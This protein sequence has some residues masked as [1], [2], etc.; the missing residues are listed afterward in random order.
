MTVQETVWLQQLHDKLAKDADVFSDPRYNGIWESIIDKYSDQAHFV[1]ELLQ[2]A[3]DA[4]ATWVRF[5]LHSQELVFRHNGKKLFTVSNPETEAE[6]QQNGKLGHVNAIAAI[7]MSQKLIENKEGNQIGKFG[8]GFKSVFRYTNTPRIYDD[9]IGFRIERRIVP[10]IIDHDYNGRLSGETVFVFPFDYGDVTKSYSEVANKLRTLQ[11]P[12][13]FLKNLKEIRYKTE[14]DDGTYSKECGE[15]QSFEYKTDGVE[16]RKLCT[17]SISIMHRDEKLNMQ[18]FTRDLEKGQAVSVAFVLNDAGQPCPSP[19][20]GAF[21]FFQT[22]VPTGLNFIVHAPFLL[23]DNRQG[24]KDDSLL[25]SSG[26]RQAGHNEQMIWECVSLAADAVWAFTQLEGERIT[27]QILEVIPTQQGSFNGLPFD[28]LFRRNVEIIQEKFIH[29][30]KNLPVIPSNGQMVMAKN[31]FWPFNHGLDKLLVDSQME[32]LFGEE[33]THWAFASYPAMHEKITPSTVPI[34]Q[35]KK[36]WGMYKFKYETRGGFL[37]RIFDNPMPLAEIVVLLTADFVQQQTDEWRSLLYEQIAE[38]RFPK[39]FLAQRNL[40]MDQYGQSMPA[41]DQ[42][43]HEQLWLPTEGVTDVH[44]VKESLMKDFNAVCLVNVLELKKVEKPSRKKQILDLIAGSFTTT[45]SLNEYMQA[46]KQVF[47]FYREEPQSQSEVIA[48]M[49]KVP[50]L[51]V[52]RCSDHVN[53]YLVP[54]GLFPKQQMYLYRKTNE[55]DKYLA[56]LEGAYTIDIGVYLNICGESFKADLQLFLKSL[57][58]R[59]VICPIKYDNGQPGIN[60]CQTNFNRL[61]KIEEHDKVVANCKATWNLLLDFIR[62]HCK[63]NRPFVNYMMYKPTNEDS[64]EVSPTLNMMRD[65]AWI[66]DLNGNL[67]KPVEIHIEDLDA[68][69]NFDTWP[70]RQLADAIGLKRITLESLSDT[71]KAAMELGRRLK[72][73]GIT[74]I[75]DA[76]MERIKKVLGNKEVD[77][78]DSI[79]LSDNTVET[80]DGSTVDGQGI[81]L[82][83]YEQTQIKEEPKEPEKHF[84]QDEEE[85]MLRVFRNDLTV[86]EMND[87][88]RLDCIRLFNS[89]KAQGLEPRYLIGGNEQREKEYD[90][91]SPELLESDFINDVFNK[92]INHSATIETNDGRI[93]H[94]IGAINGVAHLPPRWWTRIARQ[95]DKRPVKYVICAIVYHQEDGFQYLQTRADLMNAIGDR[96]TVVRIQSESKEERF[97]KTLA[98]FASDPECSDYSTYSLLL[99]H[100]MRSDTSY[101]CVFTEEF[102]EDPKG[103][104]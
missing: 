81:G 48:A 21:C 27:D 50:S 36:G 18:L 60:F 40:L 85:Q 66:I 41:Y 20:I 80:I 71:D 24:I 91:R 74:E 51:Y 8:V 96:F 76:D 30:F 22:D 101:E 89:L 3:D 37:F 38:C 13:L 44:M 61:V 68:F 87:I 90:G 92:K 6:D 47:D 94:V 84:T 64:V 98:L 100:E 102:R 59:D 73:I 43:G 88:N 28:N 10:S 93:I 25:E 23:T 56:D 45:I 9:N 69:Y 82:S 86:E 34:R 26:R 63:E 72:A 17:R 58:V 57:G 32:R 77:H 15:R 4:G 75:T 7:G 62:A 35:Y 54:D 2:N 95:T 5:E 16:V 42:Y 70:A 83:K 12:L 39:S 46:F 99:L 65:V 49:R 31:C 103:D 14:E 29:V 1:Y 53:G 97:E 78:A 67:R 19:G 55:F 11:Y 33:K 52:H 104:W 79:T